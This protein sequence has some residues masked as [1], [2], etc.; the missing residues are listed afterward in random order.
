MERILDSQ[1]MDW[2]HQQRKPYN[3]PDS[4]G[5]RGFRVS[6]LIPNVFPRYLKLLHP[7]YED[8]SIR[9]SLTWDDLEKSSPLEFDL[10]DPSQRA[11]AEVLSGKTKIYGSPNS[12]FQGKRVLWSVLCERMQL[13]F[14]P[15]INVSSFT[16]NF[17]NRS[18]PRYLVGP[19]EGILDDES[20]ELLADIL[21]SMLGDQ[22]WFFYY[23]MYANRVD[24]DIIYKARLQEFVKQLPALVENTVFGTP[25]YWF[26]ED[27]SCIVCSD[28]DLTFTLIGSSSDLC[29][30]IM[31]ETGLETVE[32]TLESR[33]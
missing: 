12:D 21:C 31:N 25:F 11:I 23:A 10:D 4:E 5:E 15:E 14:H 17:P 18:W 32:V 16:E 20:F 9:H 8:Q 13:E 3:S 26:P 19:D 29:N 30:T 6:Y 2:I 24:S 27:H 7:I 28:W 1:P 33:I 22:E